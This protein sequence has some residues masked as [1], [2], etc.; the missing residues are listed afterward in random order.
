M[1]KSTEAVDLNVRLNNLIYPL[2]CYEPFIYNNILE[3]F[4]V[5]TVYVLVDN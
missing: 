2:T 3:F 5:P 4:C 1:H